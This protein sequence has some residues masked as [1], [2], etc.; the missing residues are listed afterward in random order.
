MPFLHAATIR[1]RYYPGYYQMWDNQTLYR[2][3]LDLLSC[4]EIKSKLKDIDDCLF[5]NRYDVT[6]EFIMTKFPELL[7]ELL[8]TNDDVYYLTATTPE[9]V[10]KKYKT[11]QWCDC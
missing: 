6:V 9:A 8:K 4:N 5:I 11:I 2:I 3:N 7:P 1:D 10:R